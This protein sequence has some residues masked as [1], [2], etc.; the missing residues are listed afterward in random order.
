MGRN[1][2]GRSANLTLPAHAGPSGTLIEIGIATLGVVDAS[3]LCHK[4]FSGVESLC[5]P[6]SHTMDLKIIGLTIRQ[7]RLGDLRITASN[8]SPRRERTQGLVLRVLVQ[9][10]IRRRSM[11]GGRFRVPPCPVINLMR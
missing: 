11:T 3:I 7:R 4:Y 2:D 5:I 9:D 6:W 8:G 10:L 1:L